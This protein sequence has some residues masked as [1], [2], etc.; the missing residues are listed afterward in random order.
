MKRNK[1]T[2]A[3]YLK[4][5]LK[6]F[7]EETVIGLIKEFNSSYFLKDIKPLRNADIYL[8]EYASLGY[9]IFAITSLGTCKKGIQFRMENLQKYFGNSIK[10][11]IFLKLDEPKDK[12][13]SAFSHEKCLWIEDKYEN[14]RSG[15]KLG[16]NSF[17]MKHN[18]NDHH[19][20]ALFI[21]NLKEI[22]PF[23]KT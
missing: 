17:L 5:F 13:L 23:L 7:R 19:S 6:G 22:K 14:Y 15:E 20:D 4:E 16:F 1:N 12:A 9:D 18:Y 3:Y 11:V 2:K 21:N 10:D 8:K